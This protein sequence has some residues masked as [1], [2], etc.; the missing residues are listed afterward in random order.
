MADD[1]TAQYSFLSWVRRGI[2]TAMAP[3][4]GDPARAGVTISAT[5]DS[6][7]PG[8]RKSVV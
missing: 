5:F 1:V 2:G 7:A 8:D 4:A 6:G 3:S